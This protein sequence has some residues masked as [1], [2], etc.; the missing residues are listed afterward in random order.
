M[1]TGAKHVV[2]RGKTRVILVEKQREWNQRSCYG[3]S[4]NA[5]GVVS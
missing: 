3:S 5:D 4:G 2:C 1:R